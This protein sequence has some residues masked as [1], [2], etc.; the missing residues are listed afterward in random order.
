MFKQIEHNSHTLYNYI[1]FCSGITLYIG[2]H[3]GF[4][5][6]QPPTSMEMQQERPQCN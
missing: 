6:M 1:E 5:T 4:G 3:F 2:K